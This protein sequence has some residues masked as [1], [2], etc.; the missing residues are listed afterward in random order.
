MS[1][2]VTEAQA[3]YIRWL[4]KKVGCPIRFPECISN[5]EASWLIRDLR[6]RLGKKRA[7][8]LIRDDGYPTR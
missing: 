1:I 6:A 5:M 2:A 4:A 7:Y 8:L 3:R